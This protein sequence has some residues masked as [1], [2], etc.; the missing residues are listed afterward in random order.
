MYTLFPN[1]IC[2]QKQLSEHCYDYVIAHK[3]MTFTHFNFNNIHSRHSGDRITRE[4]GYLQVLVSRKGGS[5]CEAGT[6]EAVLKALKSDS[7]MLYDSIG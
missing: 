6:K 4:I 1:H 3:Y 7:L 2:W 5:R